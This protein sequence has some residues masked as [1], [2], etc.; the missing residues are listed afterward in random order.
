[1]SARVREHII[2]IGILL[3]LVLSGCEEPIRQTDT[4]ELPISFAISAGGNYSPGQGAPARLPGDP[5]TF[6]TFVKPS[7]AYIFVAFHRDNSGVKDTVVSCIV[8]TAILETDWIERDTIYYYNK[9]FVLD[10][11]DKDIVEDANVY[12]A[13]SNVSLAL[14]IGDDEVDK[15]D[16]ATWPTKES[17]IHNLTFNVD[18]DMQANLQ[19]IYSS[20][21]NYKPDG[22]HYYGR[23]SNFTTKVPYIHMMLYHVASK[24]D[25][26]WNVPEDNRGDVRIK[27]IT[28]EH[29]F[30]G[31]SYLFKPTHNRH[32]K[33]AGGS[34]PTHTIAT[35][36]ESTWWSGRHD[37]YTIP[38]Q[39]ADN[40]PFP[41]QIKFGVQD[42]K[43][44]DSPSD[45]NLTINKSIPASDTVF[46]SWMR[47][48]LTFTQPKS[49]SET[50]SK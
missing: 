1:M 29:L 7:Y 10:I 9:T 17:K 28:A 22:E 37:F 27:T 44:G 39:T 35:D 42:V 40:G 33:F 13:V 30:T 19:H 8:D 31:D 20:P 2:V 14:K 5:G 49:G 47:G 46:V 41:V 3:S 43:A 34:D 45:Y 18:N 4:I 38:Y 21:Y 16:K 11:A 24:V 6:E 12:L 23:V 48:Q 26:M 32:D 25:L 50:I 36:V 15:A